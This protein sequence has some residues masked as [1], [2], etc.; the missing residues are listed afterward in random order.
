MECRIDEDLGLEEHQDDASSAVSD[1]CIE[2]VP[3]RGGIDDAVDPG[4]CGR[5]KRVHRVCLCAALPPCGP[6]NTRSLVVILIHPKEVRR[7]LGTVPLL[8]LCLKNLLVYVGERFPEPEEDPKFHSKLYESGRR[9]VLV[10][11]GQGAEELRAPVIA[12]N[13]GEEADN[14]NNSADDMDSSSA[15]C[16]EARTLI[17]IDGRWRQAKTMVNRSPWLKKCLP[18]VVLVPQEQSAYGFRKQPQEGCLST[19]EAVAEALLCLEGRRGPQLKAA[20]TAPFWLMVQLQCEFIPGHVDKNV[21]VKPKPK[22]QGKPEIDAAIGTLLQETDT[23]EGTPKVVETLEEAERRR[24]EQPWRLGPQLRPK[25]VHCIVRWG[26]QAV[27]GR[28]IVVVQIVNSTL[29]EAKIRTTELS[30]GFSR[31]HRFWVLPPEKLPEDVQYEP[32]EVE[33]AS[34]STSTGTGNPACMT[35][36]TCP[37]HVEAY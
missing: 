1:D 22:I 13:S 14:G 7:P 28:N 16:G 35:M 15:E 9:P 5:C 31:G 23:A 18:R 17:L 8:K 25:K 36:T 3:R 27:A 10:C 29:D 30:R 32:L 34:F 26:E 11:P 12:E 19:L 37:E 6:I 2:Y 20:L 4:R 33:A 21:P 24:G